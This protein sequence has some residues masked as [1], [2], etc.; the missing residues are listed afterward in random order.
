MHDVIF[1]SGFIAIVVLLLLFDLGIFN[2]HSHE[3]KF[4][5]ALIWTA[6]WISFGIGFYFFILYQGHTIHGIDS[7]ERLNEIVA[8]HHH[9]VI[10]DPTDFEGS[11][12][13]YRSNLGLEYMSGYLI[14]YALS[15][16]NLF[17]MMLIFISFKVEKQH[18]K[19]VLFYGIIGAIVLRFIFIFF[20]SA[21]IHRF[22]WILYVFG[23]FLLYAG[24]KLFLHKEDDEKIDVSEHKVVKVASKWFNVYPTFIGNRFFHRESGKFFLTPLF[25]VVL[26]VEFTDVIFAVDSVPAIFSVT[27]DPFIVFFSNIFAILGLRSL[28]FVLSNIMNMFR[29]LKPGLAI[30]LIFVG[31]KLLFEFYLHKIGFETKH[32]LMVIVGILALSIILS[33][34]LPHKGK[35]SKSS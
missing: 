12:A 7:I 20:A 1:F 33:I 5:E 8:L 35:E 18:Y 10:V 15:I 30:L 27:K 22:D 11:L 26:V 34:L 17:V 29:Y 28:F 23:A 13:R 9:P 16:D 2:K 3:V 24:I 14:E 4:R 6:I 32:S 21:L 25:L 31:L 19:K